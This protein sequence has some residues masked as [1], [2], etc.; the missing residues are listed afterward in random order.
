[1]EGCKSE[2]RVNLLA[3]LVVSS[4]RLKHITSKMYDCSFLIY[5]ASKLFIIIS[6]VKQRTKS[7][8]NRHTSVNTFLHKNT[9]I[10]V[11]SVRQLLEASTL[12]I[13]LSITYNNLSRSL[14]AARLIRLKIIRKLVLFTSIKLAV[15]TK[16]KKCRINSKSSGSRNSKFSSHNKFNR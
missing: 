2:R 14:S 15:M 3:V 13:G 1:M 8:P 16:S 12:R 11:N 9:K 6:W 10:S 5:T 7:L 4:Q